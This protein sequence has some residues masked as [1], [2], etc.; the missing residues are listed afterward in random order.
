MRLD[1]IIGPGKNPGWIAVAAGSLGAGLLWTTWPIWRAMS[2]RWSTDP[3]YAHGYLVPAFAAV[4]LWLRRDRLNGLEL[5]PSWWG[6][7]LILSGLALQLSGSFFFY[8]WVEAAS[9]IPLAA[10]SCVL[11]AGVGSLRWSWPAVGFLAF[12]IPLPYRLEGMMAH[13]LQRVGTKI[14]TYAL[15]TLG[16]PAIAEGNVIQIDDVQ[17]GVVEAC[18][19]LGMI[20]TFVAMSAGVAILAQRPLLDRLAILASAV[21]ISIA[22]NVLRITA[23]GVAH[24]VSGSAA[25]GMIFHDLAGWLMM[26]AALALLW[27]ELAIL[28]RLLVE[29]GSPAVVT[30]GPISPAG[31]PDRRP[32]PAPG[33]PALAT[34]SSS[35]SSKFGPSEPTP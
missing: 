30:V 13:P 5:G 18:S 32:A 21:P 1:K 11:L 4:L 28:S 2:E 24:R 12:M 25:A 20:F 17:I 27:L 15:Q 14:S 22:V 3:R 10:G 29:A 9:L 26:P 7:L 34:R 19:G 16:L 6:V 8:E 23:T 33:F 35:R 31:R